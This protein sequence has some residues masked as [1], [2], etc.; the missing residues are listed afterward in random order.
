[1]IF[2]VEVSS[3]LALKAAC[4]WVGYVEV[5]RLDFREVFSALPLLRWRLKTWGAVPH[6][7][8]S[9][10]A[11]WQD[12]LLSLM[13]EC[14]KHTTTWLPGI[15]PFHGPLFPRTPQDRCLQGTTTSR[16]GQ[17]GGDG[18]GGEWCAAME[19]FSVDGVL[20][21]PASSP[22]QRAFIRRVII[23]SSFSAHKDNR[24]L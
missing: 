6:V 17:T 24:V 23:A 2:C 4:S 20:S 21:L 3:L 12:W 11:S 13:N 8:I 10:T 19:P 7:V 18:E 22:P 9:W 15:C 1:M 5:L 16:G 14:C